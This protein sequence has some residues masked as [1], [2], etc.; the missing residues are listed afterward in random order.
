[1]GCVV[2]VYIAKKKSLEGKPFGFVRFIKVQDANKLEEH[3]N[4]IQTGSVKIRVNLAKFAR[5]KSMAYSEFQEVGR[6]NT[7]PRSYTGVRVKTRSYANVVKKDRCSMVEVRKL[8]GNSQKMRNS[9]ENVQASKVERKHI[10]IS[11][12]LTN[13][14]WLNRAL[15]GDLLSYDSL[16][17][18]ADICDEEGLNAASGKYIGGMKVLLIFETEKEA[19]DVLSSGHQSVS[20]WINNIQRWDSNYKTRQHLSWIYIEG[21]PLSVWCSVSFLKIATLFGKVIVPEECSTDSPQLVL[22]K[23]CIL[24]S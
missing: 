22:G 21:L 4:S 13:N 10:E 7:D 24:T 11:T 15:V 16:E 5:K 8:E 6:K 3:L 17:N 12:G 14:D 23:V 18:V 9:E 1:Y 19:N 20:R 2:D